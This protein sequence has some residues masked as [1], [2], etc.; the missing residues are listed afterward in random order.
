[1][2]MYLYTILLNKINENR[3]FHYNPHAVIIMTTD[4]SCV[5]LVALILLLRLIIVITL[6]LLPRCIWF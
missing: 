6:F 1:M 3:T 4:S 2:E 5:D